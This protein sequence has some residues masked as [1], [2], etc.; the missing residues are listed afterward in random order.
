MGKKKTEI[1]CLT[2]VFS[3][4]KEAMETSEFLVA[5]ILKNSWWQGCDRPLFSC[6]NFPLG[7]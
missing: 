3:A 7:I 1:D 4:F 6:L 5:R 2:V